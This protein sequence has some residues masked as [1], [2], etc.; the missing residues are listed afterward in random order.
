MKCA[1]YTSNELE[2][3]LFSLC[4]SNRNEVFAIPADT[5]SITPL[6]HDQEGSMAKKRKTKAKAAAKKGAK[7][8]KRRKKK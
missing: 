6:T 2:T 1:P 3:L 7:K 5:I 4:C 8:A